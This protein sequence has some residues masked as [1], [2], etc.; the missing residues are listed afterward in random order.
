MKKLLALVL[1]MVMTL[2]LATVGASAAAYTDAADIDYTEAVDVMSALKVLDGQNGAF[3][4]NGVLTREQGAKIIAYMIL[5]KSAAD[6]LTTAKSSFADVAPERWSAGSIEYC[7]STKIVGGAG[8]DANGNDVFNPE[9]ELTGYAFAKMCLVALGYNPN[10]ESFVGGDWAINVAK[11]AADAGLDKNLAGLVMSDGITRQQAAQMALNTEKATMVEYDNPINVKGSDGMEVVVGAKREKVQAASYNYKWTNTDS[12]TNEDGAYVQFVERYNQSPQVKM[13]ADFDD[14]GSPA[15]Y[16]RQ[17]N[18]NIGKYAKTATV[19]Y[20]AAVKGGVVYSDLGGSSIDFANMVRNGTAGTNRVNLW[21]DG[22]KEDLTAAPNAANVYDKDLAAVIKSGNTTDNLPGSGNGV[23]TEIFYNRADNTLDIIQ[24]RTYLVKALAAYDA[25]RKN[26]TVSVANLAGAT[27][28]GQTALGTLATISGT[29]FPVVEGAAKDTYFYITFAVDGTKASVK[30]VTPVAADRFVSG[31]TISAISSSSMTADGQSYSK[32]KAFASGANT[33]WDTANFT[34][35]STKYDLI[36]DPNGYVLTTAQT[37]AS[38][39]YKDKYIYVWNAG[40][41]GLSAQAEIIKMD[42]SAATVTVS[43]TKTTAGTATAVTAAKTYARDDANLVLGKTT[44]GASDG[45][46]FS[47]AFYTYSLN[48][49]N[50]YTLTYVGGNPVAADI[51]KNAPQ[52]NAWT[53]AANSKTAFVVN[54]TPSNTSNLSA[55]LGIA[56]FPGATVTNGVYVAVGNTVAAVYVEGT[57]TNSSTDKFVYLFSGATKAQDSA[58]SSPYLLFDAFI[59][60]AKSADKI[61]VVDG[62]TAGLYKV[63]YNSKGRLVADNTTKVGNADGQLAN[64]YAVAVNVYLT[65]GNGN[66]TLVDYDGAAKGNGVYT[67]ASDVEF[68]YVDNYNTGDSVTY[69]DTAAAASRTKGGAY[70][71]AVMQKSTSDA[72]ISK[73]WI[74][75][76]NNDGN[77]F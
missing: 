2:G 22:N 10:Y 23:K 7:V 65:A 40:S 63:S 16:W 72:S 31:A 42:G 37:T 19:T 35:Q 34:L 59:D 12:T 61:S 25:T 3:N 46:L 49:D 44:Y 6:G 77:V 1:A 56:N 32:A 20:T 13:T 60:G 76:N 62:A 36:L 67:L 47:K 48:D 51:S 18:A 29:D 70:M 11:C 66:I 33:A 41:L 5:G 73:V 43:K 38:T 64:S 57:A 14:F 50:T 74:I 9:A 58:T 30:T 45:Y 39:E 24:T 4:P 15:N 68:Y 71:I 26:I 75:T 55:Y 54:G 8:K 28:T 69:T 52:Q 27:A 21:V 53:G 17:G